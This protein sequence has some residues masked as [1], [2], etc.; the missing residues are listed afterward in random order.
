MSDPTGYLGDIKVCELRLARE[1]FGC[2]VVR[3]IPEV[4]II[5]AT[6]QIKPSRISGAIVF[7]RELG[8]RSWRAS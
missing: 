8:F 7:A 6:P 1:G 3:D 2:C 4:V 5:D